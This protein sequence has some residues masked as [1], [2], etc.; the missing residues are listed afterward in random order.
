MEKTDEKKNYPQA[1][2]CK[3]ASRLRNNVESLR[4]SRVPPKTKKK[5]MKLSDDEFCGDYGMTLKFLMDG[6]VDNNQAEMIEKIN[7]LESRIYTLENK[8]KEE[9]EGKQIKTLGGKILT[10]RKGECLE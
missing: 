6:I 2:L 5:F 4:I 7:E 1:D 8:P 3:L 10:K 9:D